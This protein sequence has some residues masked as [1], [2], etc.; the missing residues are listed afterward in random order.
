MSVKVGDKVPSAKMKQMSAEGPKD[1][2]TDDFFK[3][4]KVA[5][6][7]VPGA[8][9]PTCSAKHLPGFVEKAAELKKK[10]ID[11]IACVSVNDAFVMD[12]WGKAQNVGD[13]VVMLGDGN[14]EFTRAMGLELDGT[15]NGLGKRS[16]RYA[17]VVDNGVIKQLFVE[18]PRAFE[19]SSADH[20]L[21]NL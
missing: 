1:V 13:K 9:T 7:A 16:Q 5:L 6:F 3:G 21:K 2:S 19:V 4:K 8:F 15:P 18:Q 14:G 17:M 11:T 10:G 12:A 20:M